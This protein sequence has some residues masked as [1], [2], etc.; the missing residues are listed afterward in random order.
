[1]K[2][3]YFT[4]SDVVSSNR[5][6]YTPSSFARASLLYLQEI[7]TLQAL[8]PHTSSRVHCGEIDRISDRY[9]R[10]PVRRYPG[11]RRG[12]KGND[13]QR[14]AVCT[15]GLFAIALLPKTSKETLA[16]CGNLY[17][18]KRRHR[19]ASGVDRTRYG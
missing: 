11:R 3:K 10:S 19:T 8:K 4:T 16:C 12:S 17:R 15:D 9:F 6:L 14:G 7:G 1:M 2:S 18:C 13:L 5:V